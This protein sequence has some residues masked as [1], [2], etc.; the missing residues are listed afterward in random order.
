LSDNIGDGEFF[1]G[2]YW[3]GGN[4]AVGPIGNDFREI[5]Y[6]DGD[7]W[8]SPQGG[9]LG[10]SAW[11]NSLKSYKGLLYVGGYFSSASGN[12]DDFLMA[13]DGSQWQPTF[14]DVQFTAQVHD[15]VVIDDVLHIVGQHMVWNGTTWEGPYGL[16]RFDGQQFCSFGGTEVYA[17]QIAGLN[18]D[19]YVTTAQTLRGDT[20]N[21][22][23]KW[24]QGSQ[25]DIC[26]SVS[27]AAA[28]PLSRVEAV[29]LFPNPAHGA[30]SL[31]L[32]PQAG[33]C[34][35]RIVDLAGQTVLPP[36]T[37]TGGDVDVSMLPAGVYFVEVDWRGGREVVKLVRE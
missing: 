3:F 1:E 6:F 9:I 20:V 34:T 19:L 36:R 22:I 25:D 11:V 24:P 5:M 35:L 31:R 7:Q 10:L 15:L 8:Q 29:S 33:A 26:V 12:A 30:F 32:P 18:G 21:W 16:A 37:Y 27:T 23:A 17:G 13:W 28:A 2:D 4:F 14:P